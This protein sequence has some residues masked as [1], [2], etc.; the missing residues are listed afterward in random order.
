MLPKQTSKGK[1]NAVVEGFNISS[2]DTLAIIESDLT[3]ANS[4]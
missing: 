2:G 4:R 1:K 3:F